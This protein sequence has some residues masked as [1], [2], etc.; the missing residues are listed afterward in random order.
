MSYMAQKLYIVCQR[1]KLYDKKT[2]F[3]YSLRCNQKR[4]EEDCISKNL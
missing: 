1:L 4:Y 2:V 3:Q